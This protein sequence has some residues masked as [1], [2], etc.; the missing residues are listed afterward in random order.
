MPPPWP[1]ELNFS[2]YA[3]ADKLK[4]LL[5]NLR[6]LNLEGLGLIRVPLRA[7][8]IEEL[9]ERIGDARLSS[10]ALHGNLLGDSGVEALVRRPQIAGLTSLSLGSNQIAGEG[11]RA[12]ARSPHIANL[13]TLK[14]PAN[15]V[16]EEGLAE[17]GSSPHLRGLRTLNL[18]SNPRLTAGG[19]AALFAG[20][21]LAQ[22]ASLELSFNHL[23]VGLIEGLA[24][25]FPPKLG[26]LVLQ[27]CG[28]GDPEARELASLLPAL[29]SLRL[30][31]NN[32]GPSGVKWLAARPSDL[33]SL[34]LRGSP[35]L[36]AGAHALLAG[37]HLR[38]LTSL[39]LTGCQIGDTGVESLVQRGP[40]YTSLRLTRNS[41]SEASARRLAQGER[42]ARL[43]ELALSGNSMD[44]A[45]VRAL[46]DSPLL[47]NLEI[48][49]LGD[50]KLGSG[51]V[52]ALSQSPYLTR[53]TGL[54]LHRSKLQDGDLQTLLDSPL[55]ASVTSL[56]L[57][58]NELTP[59]GLKALAESPHSSRLKSLRLH[60]NHRLDLRALDLLLRA[61]APS[62]L[63]SL[64]ISHL[65][66]SENQQLKRAYPGVRFEYPVRA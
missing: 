16:A 33:R 60:N 59:T 55:L 15:L 62:G 34:D 6:E 46:A 30:A 57:S 26:E 38:G 21:S 47:A 54:S 41:L 37:P 53:L 27:G 45:G 1:A 31:E 17:L 2:G 28:L 25:H 58:D 3:S 50:M 32:L 14:L 52:E 20:Q 63:A 24:R 19:L 40:A 42:L 43:R 13:H 22:L 66:D 23:D 29:T 4:P 39:D 44:V 56:D 51:L 8:A 35:I 11:L 64:A 18:Q 9:T 65:Q 48:L 10:L 7:E 12:I 5:F 49:E 36:A 61:R